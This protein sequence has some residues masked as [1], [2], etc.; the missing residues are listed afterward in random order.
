MSQNPVAAELIRPHK[1]GQ[2]A[3]KSFASADFKLL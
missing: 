2:S 1:E 3:L